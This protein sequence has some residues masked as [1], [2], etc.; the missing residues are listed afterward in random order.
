MTTKKDKHVVS[1]R[2]RK[3]YA[4]TGLRACRHLKELGKISRRGY[5]HFK[6]G[7]FE[8]KKQAYH[9][10]DCR[11]GKE[12]YEKVTMYMRR[13]KIQ[14]DGFRMSLCE[15]KT[16]RTKICHKKHG[17]YSVPL[18]KSGFIRNENELQ[19]FKGVNRLIDNDLQTQAEAQINKSI[20][21]P[22]NF[23]V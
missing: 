21:N 20:E 1:L 7:L 11:S 3:Y 2:Q 8:P 16:A 19:F 13:L 18:T 23:R 12:A 5:E 6:A 15:P 9:W 17:I 4:S 10:R 22:H 14:K